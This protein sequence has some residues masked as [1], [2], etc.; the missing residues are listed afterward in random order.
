MTILEE[1]QLEA[2]NKFIR[3]LEANGRY[4]PQKQSI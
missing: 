1:A 3:R 4:W 2:T